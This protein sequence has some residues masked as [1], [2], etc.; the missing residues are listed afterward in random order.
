MPIYIKYYYDFIDDLIKAYQE[1]REKSFTVVTECCPDEDL[2]P[3]HLMLGEATVDTKDY[4]RS[5]FRQYFISSPLFNSQQQL[6][7]ET[8]LL[9]DR[10]VQ[11]TKNF[12]IT[13]SNSR[14]P[15]PIRITPSKWSQAPLSAR[16]IPYYYNINNVA[17]SWS[18]QKTKRGKSNHNLSY[19]A[20]KYTVQPSDNVLNPLLYSIEPYNFYRIEGH[21]GYEFPTVLNTILSL[22]NTWKPVLN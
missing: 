10:M 22:K 9:F 19:N 8:K 5:P 7:S 18:V 21:I 12:F 13:Q 3:M 16:S 2:F 11:L 1:F 15:V 14:Q 4:T 6:L 20:D 17:R